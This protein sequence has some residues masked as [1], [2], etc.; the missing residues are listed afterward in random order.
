MRED[1]RREREEEEEAK[2][3]FFS[4]AE[5]R[6]S[7]DIKFI[8]YS[9]VFIL[10]FALLGVVTFPSQPV[11]GTRLKRK[12]ETG[13]NEVS[14]KE[15]KTQAQL[16]QQCSP[17]KVTQCILLFLP[18][19]TECSPEC[20]SRHLKTVERVKS[21]LKDR[22][23]GWLWVEAGTQMGLQ[24][25]LGGVEEGVHL[26]VAKFGRRT[27]WRMKLG[28]SPSWLYGWRLGDTLRWLA[29]WVD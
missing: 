14:I 29:G 4:E 11:P 9:S 16:F 7:D 27:S 26:I 28:R 13:N 6:N 3:K 2:G 1:E 21:D 22:L 25:S 17:T 20:R 8:K 24:N 23:W 5:R 15:L 12:A 19:L 10:I 18:P